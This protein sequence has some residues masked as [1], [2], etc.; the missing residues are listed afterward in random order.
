MSRL[1][2]MGIIT[3]RDVTTKIENALSPI[4]VSFFNVSYG[5]GTASNETLNILGIGESE[6]SI[7][8]CFVEQENIE[9]VFN[10]LKN[11]FNF[12]KPASGIA[13]TVP[14]SAVGGPATLKILTE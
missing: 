9:K 12:D 5:K 10:T 14:L 11:D 7:I 4:G 8:F 13:F 3:N 6:K 2:M 1:K